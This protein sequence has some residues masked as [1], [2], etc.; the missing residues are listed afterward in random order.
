MLFN[1]GP[2]QDLIR[3]DNDLRKQKRKLSEQRAD[4]IIKRTKNP[5]FASLDLIATVHED[6]TLKQMRG[7]FGFP[8][9]KELTNLFWKNQRR[10][11]EFID[12][13]NLQAGL[14]KANPGYN[15]SHAWFL[16]N[17]PEYAS[18]FK[19][20]TPKELQE[21]RERNWKMYN[22]L[23]MLMHKIAPKYGSLD[24]VLIPVKS[25]IF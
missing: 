10:F 13:N 25:P 7:Y 4:F 19:E 21:Y 23:C 22:G 17:N 14:E 11:L 20:L 2:D 1:P 9:K 16:H 15:Y 6:L 18:Q 5:P 24:A 3:R 8:R 12:T